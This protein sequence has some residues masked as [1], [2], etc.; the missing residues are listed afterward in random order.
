MQPFGIPKNPK[1]TVQTQKKPPIQRYPAPYGVP[2]KPTPTG[3]TPQKS[4]NP[5]AEDNTRDPFEINQYFRQPGSLDENEGPLQTPESL[6]SFGVQY[7]GEKFS[8][9]KKLI[10]FKGYA[11]EETPAD[12]IRG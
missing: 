4:A 12:L 10:Y 7:Q 6:G 8:R 5:F 3:Q 9:E 1:M 11:F 2:S